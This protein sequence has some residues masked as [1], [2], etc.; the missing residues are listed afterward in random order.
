MNGGA[1]HSVREVRTNSRFRGKENEFSFNA[2][3]D[4]LLGISI[5]THFWGYLYRHIL[6]SEVL[7][8]S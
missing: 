7:D 4:S 8:N 3:F 5:R 2:N 1:I 6:V